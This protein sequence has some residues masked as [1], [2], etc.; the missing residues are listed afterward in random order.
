M[1]ERKKPKGPL[2]LKAFIH[3]RKQEIKSEI[4]C[5]SIGTIES[6]DATDQTATV[7]IN[8]Q[9]V[10]FDQAPVSEGL[11]A[12]KYINYE[13]LV[14]CPVVIIGGGTGRITFPIAK[15]DTC[16][17]FF[18][19]KEIDTWFKTGQITYPRNDRMHDLTDAFVL[20]GVSS[21]QNKIASVYTSGIE[22]TFGG[23][24]I[25]IDSSGIIRITNKINMFGTTENKSSSYGA[26]QATTD[27]TVEVVI[28]EAGNETQGSA[29]GYTDSNA[30]PSTL[31]R[32]DSVHNGGTP[33]HTKPYGGFTMQVRKGDYWKV[34][35]SGS[36]GSIGV[37]WLPYGVTI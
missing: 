21:T 37:R 20:V 2:D 8:Y 32:A 28:T 35:V 10:I 23:A 31:I 6:F 26:Q 30:D 27:G 36:I 1:N 19:D 5:V 13:A 22:L 4:N 17:L 24:S 33:N 34:V 18:C 25:R 7:R 3:R 16:L 9:K 14:K 29:L 11:D 12:D 15:G